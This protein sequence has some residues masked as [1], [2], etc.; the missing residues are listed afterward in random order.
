MIKRRWL[1]AGALFF[2]VALLVAGT[3]DAAVSIT[4]QKGTR[5]IKAAGYEATVAPDGCLTSIRVKGQELLQASTAGSRGTYFYLG[6]MLKLPQITQPAA[7]VIE[8]KCDRAA[9]RY[10]FAD[11]TMAWTATNAAQPTMFFIIFDPNVN[12][13]MN[14]TGELAKS[15]TV[16]PWGH[17]TWFRGPIRVEITGGTK[18]WGPWNGLQVWEASLAANETRV[19]KLA[20]G[21]ASAKEAA[22]VKNITVPAWLKKADLVVYTPKQYQ[23]FQR[24]TRLSGTIAFSG[25]V[26]PKCDTVRVRI[27]GKSLKGDLPGT[28][29][30]LALVPGTQAF[31]GR[32]ATTSGGWYQIDIEAL[33]GGKSVARAVI[34]KVGVGEVFVG[35][36]QS[37]STNCG[38]Q[39]IQQTS[40]MVSSFS[41]EH[42][43]LAN[44]PQPGPHDRSQDGS[45]WPALGDA[46]FE[47]YG[48][49]IGVAVT[50][51]GGT[52]VNQ[53]NPGGELHNW[54]MT[55]IRQLGPFGFRAV[56][57]HQGE[58]DV[59]MTA[60][61]YYDKM[62]AVIRASTWQA[63]WQFP[64][65][66]AQV[67][68]HN[69]QRPSFPTTR[70]AH[71]RLWDTG[72]AL[73]GPDTDTLTGDTRDN[74]GKGIH[75]S[76]K[77]LKLHGKMWADKLAP[78]IDA[79]LKQGE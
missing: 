76:P 74:G 48:V 33:L 36:G 41:G 62:S 54:M 51:H 5:Q 14:A 60:E 12:A 6:G 45:F 17:T 24:R 65:A 68:Y 78:Y 42:W 37:N 71:K 46:M 52:S 20:F 28:W 64:W 44:D 69:P 1:V 13:V 27:T 56:L 59:G 32:L 75:F 39:R 10:E 18:L 19:I 31:S 57:W 72:V 55:R 25:R 63:G 4:E 79:A 73:E 23:V 35:A 70:A 7:N 58:S 9:I 16:K 66:V 49:P 34:E 21:T 38:Q 67:S 30:P 8:A 47:K 50:G 53:W 77:G 11:N 3:A 40:G 2:A 43:Q 29:Q 26:T 22:A 15:P 61:Q